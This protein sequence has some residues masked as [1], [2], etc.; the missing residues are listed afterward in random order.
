M[1]VADS[2]SELIPA[3][4]PLRRDLILLVLPVLAE[5]LLI[6]GIGFFDTLLS[7]QLGRQETAA[8][9]LAAYVSWLGSVIFGVVSVGASAIV[10]RHWERAILRKLVA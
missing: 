9:G 5:Q 10:A 4:D 8:I 7:G 6:F 3:T 2:S 1:P